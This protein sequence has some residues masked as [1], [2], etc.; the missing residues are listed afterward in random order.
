MTLPCETLRSRLPGPEPRE[1]E[2]PAKRQDGLLIA[3]GHELGL[4]SLERDRE[5]LHLG[6]AGNDLSLTRAEIER[7]VCGALASAIAA[8]GPI[9][10]ATRA[11]A[12]K[13]IV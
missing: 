13:R 7:E 10:L 12:A 2:I 11:S 6:I 8:H 5:S 3:P 9:T 1:V 4:G